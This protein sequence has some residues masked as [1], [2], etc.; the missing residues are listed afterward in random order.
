MGSVTNLCT[1]HIAT[2]A[3]TLSV[4]GCSDKT[5]QDI[6]NGRYLPVRT[7][8]GKAVWRREKSVGDVEV[9]PLDHI[10]SISPHV[11]PG[12]VEGVLGMRLGLSVGPSGVPG[13]SQWV[14]GVEGRRIT[15]VV[16]VR[17]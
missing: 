3:P 12:L 4:V 15:N 14:P 17:Q 2:G 6:V 11:P 13:G 8:H 5:I 16:P 9:Q 1:H 7:N 10:H